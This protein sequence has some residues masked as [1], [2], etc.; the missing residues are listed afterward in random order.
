MMLATKNYLSVLENTP[1][2]VTHVGVNQFITEVYLPDKRQHRF[3]LVNFWK[4]ASSPQTSYKF[5][6]FPF[7]AL[8]TAIDLCLEQ[9]R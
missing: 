6:E 8:A 9:V 4:C 2:L 1:I 7:G 5:C 3:D